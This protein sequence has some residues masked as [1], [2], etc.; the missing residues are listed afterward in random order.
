MP[1]RNEPQRPPPLDVED[2]IRLW[3]LQRDMPLG[4]AARDLLRGLAAW[5]G[6]DFEREAAAASEERD[7]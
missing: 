5:F 3:A 6:I 4:E 1:T 7:S 2:V